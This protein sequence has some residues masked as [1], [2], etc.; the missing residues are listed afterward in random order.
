MGRLLLTS[1]NADCW[2]VIDK[3]EIPAHKIILSSISPVFKAMFDHDCEESK[4]G[5]I[6][7]K[8]FSLEAMKVIHNLIYEQVNDKLYGYLEDV[9]RFADRYN[10]DE[11]TKWITNILLKSLTFENICETASGAYSY[12]DKGT[13]ISDLYEN[14]LK[15]LVSN[16]LYV[17]EMEHF[18]GMHPGVAKDILERIPIPE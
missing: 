9:Y 17:S 4:T 5:K 13:E 12:Q 14:C 6:R 15:I 1:N 11:F 2:L 3:E 7:I 16:Y 18:D 8:D 10:M